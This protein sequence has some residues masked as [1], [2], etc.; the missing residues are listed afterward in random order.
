MSRTI[1]FRS[2]EGAAPQEVCLP[3]SDHLAASG[4][5]ILSMSVAMISFYCRSLSQ[6]GVRYV[7]DRKPGNLRP[8]FGRVLLGPLEVPR[9]MCPGLS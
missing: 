9:H 1:A 2:P 4:Y 5:Q 6:R 7:V 8:T 3:F